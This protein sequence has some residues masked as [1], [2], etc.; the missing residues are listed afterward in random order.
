M[1]P[2]IQEHLLTIRE[3]AELLRLKPATIRK[4]IASGLLEAA[5]IGKQLYTSREALSRAAKPVE[6]QESESEAKRLQREM[7]RTAR[8]RFGMR[9]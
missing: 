3:A 7:E 6:R 8:Q 2:I 4:H 1:S 9:L 5:K